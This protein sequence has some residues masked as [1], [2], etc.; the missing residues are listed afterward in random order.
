MAHEGGNWAKPINR[1]VERS[2]STFDIEDQISISTI[3]KEIEE[4]SNDFV[5]S[6]NSRKDKN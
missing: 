2:D 6:S 1:V 4:Y 5:V 3:S